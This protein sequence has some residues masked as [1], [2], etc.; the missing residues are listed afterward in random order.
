MADLSQDGRE[1]ET[2]RELVTGAAPPVEDSL[3]LLRTRS[4]SRRVGEWL[5]EEPFEG[6]VLAVFQRACLLFLPG[7]NVAALVG[8]EIGEG[9]LN[10]VLARPDAS[11]IERQSGVFSGI[12][13]GMVACLG[14]SLQIGELA[15][16][17]DGAD[18]WE[19][20]PDWEG[21]RR[22]RDAIEGRLLAVHK[23]AQRQFPEGSLF[24][25]LP[26]QITGSR[27][28]TGLGKPVRSGM[29]TAIQDALQ[30]LRAAW[31]GDRAAVLALA[32]SLAGLG[33]GLTPAGDDMLAGVMLWAWL[34]HRDPRGF[35][36]L[37]LEAAATRTTTLSS[38][39]LRAAAEGECSA[40][41]HE[42]LAAL[43]GGPEQRLE[44]ALTKV[45]SFG[46]T[47]G[48]DTLAGF[49]SMGLPST[50]NGIA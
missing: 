16:S 26:D 38:S 30:Y 3:P 20:R 42:L 28:L 40:A 15:V 36:A 46:H 13:P 14:K 35:C 9:P 25:L 10:I 37:L 23:L 47:S 49:A 4:I 50:Q 44:A 2:H 45:L 48:A 34:A 31:A 17:L 39:F 12:E 8:P 7:D 43:A 5:Q 24:G 11:L 41:W 33:E 22:K 27:D 18:L 6:E 21:L 29:M 1:A 32:R 19:P